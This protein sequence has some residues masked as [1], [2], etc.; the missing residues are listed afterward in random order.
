[1]TALFLILALLAF[2]AIGVGASLLR[3]NHRPPLAG[4]WSARVRGWFATLH[5]QR[6][7]GAALIAGG[8]LALILVLA[9]RP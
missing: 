8:A 7:V 2:A 1:M 3:A 9:L 5:A 6:A 4:S